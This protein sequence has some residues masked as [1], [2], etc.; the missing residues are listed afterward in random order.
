MRVGVTQIRFIGEGSFFRASS[1]IFLKAAWVLYSSEKGSTIAGDLQASEIAKTI[2]LVVNGKADVTVLFQSDE[3]SPA[4]R[5]HPELAV[6]EAVF[7]WRAADVITGSGGE[8]AGVVLSD[9]LQ[10][11][12]LQGLFRHGSLFFVVP[13]VGSLFKFFVCHL[14]SSQQNFIRFCYNTI[15]EKKQIGNWRKW[16]ME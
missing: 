2:I 15:C 6:M 1:G 3:L 13:I 12:L 5:E 4:F 9:V 16:C 11:S 7:D 14:H 10:N 8:R